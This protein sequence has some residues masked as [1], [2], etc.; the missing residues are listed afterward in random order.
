[1]VI[2]IALKKLKPHN[3]KQVRL[4]KKKLFKIKKQHG[5]YVDKIMKS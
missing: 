4:A 1:M 3:S 5:D 2:I